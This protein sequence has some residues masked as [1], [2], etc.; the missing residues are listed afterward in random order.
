MDF[1]QEYRPEDLGVIGAVEEMIARAV[2][3]SPLASHM[4]KTGPAGWS[5]CRK[6]LNIC[7]VVNYSLFGGIGGATMEISIHPLSEVLDIWVSLHRP[8]FDNFYRVFFGI[9]IRLEDNLKYFLSAMYDFLFKLEG[10]RLKMLEFKS[11]FSQACVVSTEEATAI[12]LR[13]PN[14]VEWYVKE[15]CLK[16]KE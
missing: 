8:E 12:R 7:G 4:T 5:G 3:Q 6:K 15:G 16:N 11:K 10:E 13:Y 14:F 9:G 1:N 2:E